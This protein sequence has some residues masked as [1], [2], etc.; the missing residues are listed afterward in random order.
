MLKIL[1]IITFVWIIY[2]IYRF[3]LGIQ[4]TNNNKNKKEKID[5]KSKMDIQDAEYEDIE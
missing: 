4:I 1:F 5:S 3:I 2:Q